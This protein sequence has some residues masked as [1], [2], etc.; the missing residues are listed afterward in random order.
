MSSECKV[1]FQKVQCESSVVRLET[2]LF[3]NSEALNK[4]PTSEL[5]FSSVKWRYLSFLL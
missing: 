5:I 4:S 3:Y 2:G 1:Y